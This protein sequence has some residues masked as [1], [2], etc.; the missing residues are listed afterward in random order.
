MSL[1]NHDRL[2]KILPTLHYTGTAC[3][4]LNL[5]TGQAEYCGYDCPTLRHRMMNGDDP[6]VHLNRWPTENGD[7]EEAITFDPGIIV[8]VS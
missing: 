2:D 6:G 8:A 4:S 1:T 7:P 3:G 5:S